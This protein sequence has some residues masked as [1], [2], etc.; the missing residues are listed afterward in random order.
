DEFRAVDEAE[1]HA[2]EIGAVGKGGEPEVEA[3]SAEDATEAGALEQGGIVAELASDQ[4]GERADPREDGD[5][6]GEDF[7]AAEGDAAAV[8]DDVHHAVRVARNFQGLQRE[9]KGE[10]IC[11]SAAAHLIAAEAGNED[12][13]VLA[14]DEDVIAGL[15]RGAGQGDGEKI[16]NVEADQ[17]E[18]LAEAV[19]DEEIATG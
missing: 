10:S 1:R 15:R 11:A 14:A 19:A 17:R 6:D 18:F 8:I 13:V 2:V 16:A 3:T 5:L 12:V 4:L 9:V 7:D